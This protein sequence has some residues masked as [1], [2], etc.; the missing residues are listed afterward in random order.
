MRIKHKDVEYELDLDAAV[1]CGS[2]KKLPP[3]PLNAGDVYKHPT[4]RVNSFLLVQIG[5]NER[6]QL[7]GVRGV[8]PN[9][10][11]FFE[12]GH[13]LTEIRE[14]LI[15]YEMVFHKNITSEIEDLLP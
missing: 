7:L 6:Y 8:R 2:A 14:Y 12:K 9:S 5:W 10:G 1:R 3:Y 15:E 4:G 13:S 11:N